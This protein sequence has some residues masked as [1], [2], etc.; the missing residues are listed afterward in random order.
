MAPA[1]SIVV[2]VQH[3]QGNL[4]DI[5]AALRPEAYPEIEFI[6]CHTPAESRMREL[7]GCGENVRVL[8]GPAGTLIPEMWR[9]GILAARGERVA[10]TTAHCIPHVDWVERLVAAKLDDAVAVGGLIENAFDSDAKGWAIH[11]L[12]YAAF[13][14]PEPARETQDLAADNALYSR[15]AIVRHADLLARGFWEPSFHARF[16]AEGLSLKLEPA[17][18]VTHRNRYTAAQFAAQRLGHGYEFGRTR[19]N[20]VPW[21][22]RLLLMLLSPGV[23]IVLMRRILAAGREKP[24]LGH[25]LPRASLWLMAFLLSWSLGEAAG[26]FTSLI[27]SNRKRIGVPGVI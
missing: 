15:H 26:Y 21:R 20:A 7:I 16:R 23:P 1:L 24:T 19:G 13:T 22:K 4:V 10:T 9:D 3:A 6:F 18:R 11:M 25:H 27:T 5:M 8:C 14:P 17:L 2:A 12:R